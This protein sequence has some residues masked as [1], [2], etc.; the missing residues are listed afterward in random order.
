MTG[1]LTPDQ[2]RQYWDDGYLFPLDIMPKEEAASWRAQ[3]ETIESDWLNNDLPLPLN[4]YKRVNSHVVMPM[5]ARLA[6]DPRVLDIVEGVLGPNILVW[7]AEFFIKEPGTKAFVSMH[8]DLTYWGLGA[9]DGLVTAWIALSPATVSSGCMD[10]VKGSHKNPI[11]PHKDTHGEDN[12]LS[13]GQ[14]I[15]VD[16]A[17]E[18]QTAIELQP[19]QMS[20]HHGLT[21]HGSGPNVSNDRRIGFVIRYIKPEIAQQV[22][23]KDYAMLVRGVDHIGNFI[24]LAP[25]SSLFAQQSLDL[26]EEIRKA[27]AAALMKGSKDTKR[28]YG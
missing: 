20:L 7:S 1:P 4:S 15:S 16:I 12:L 28:L 25:P 13:R 9:I 17:P 26:Y 2:Q 3:I 5:A 19:G 27:Q 22:A 18:D 11:L 21:I 6:A 8:Q 24:H 23:D 14:E 10:F